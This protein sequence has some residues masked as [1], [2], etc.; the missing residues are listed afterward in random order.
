ML[1]CWEKKKE[2]KKMNI[3]VNVSDGN[4]KLKFGNFKKIKLIGFPG[5]LRMHCIFVMK[6]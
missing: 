3:L 6:N 2:K 4:V 1:S 5:K